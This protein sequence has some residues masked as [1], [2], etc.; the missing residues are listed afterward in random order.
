M[1]AATRI[2]VMAVV[3]IGNVVT[4]AAS[5]EKSPWSFKLDL[6]WRNKYLAAPDN[7]VH[8]DPVFQTS[9]TAAHTSGWYF[10]V[11]HDGEVGSRFLDRENGCASEVDMTAGWSGKVFDLD[12]DT[13]VSWWA[14]SDLADFKDDDTIYI[15]NQ[16][17]KTYELSKKHS[18]TPFFKT[19]IYTLPNTGWSGDG[20]GFHGGL[21]HNWAFS[22]QLSICSEAKL[23]YDDGV[24]GCDNGLLGGLST[25]LSWKIN[26]KISIRA[27]Y[28]GIFTPLQ[29][30]SDSRETE[31]IFGTGLTW[32][33]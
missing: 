1:K 32:S 33:F 4:L 27:P 22:E 31:F 10:N 2:I 21:C 30:L 26:D 14:I 25:T 19:N 17:S 24:Y 18:I 28:L 29:H 9:I 6:D 3:L 11:W 8:D 15:Y 5:E 20:V 23:M 16:I 12:I 13:G 7:V